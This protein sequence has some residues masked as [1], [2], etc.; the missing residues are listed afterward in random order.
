MNSRLSVYCLTWDAT[1]E[2][3]EVSEARLKVFA[4]TKKIKI[5]K[6]LRR[7]T[8]SIPCGLHRS[9]TIR[10][11]MNYKCSSYTKS[12]DYIRAGLSCCHDQQPCW[13]HWGLTA[14]ATNEITEFWLL[15]NESKKCLDIKYPDEKV[16]RQTPLDQISLQ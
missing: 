11:K 15:S 10:M 5:K 1:W 13:P 12:K 16:P 7:I 4:A 3:Q 14:A 6:L 2:Q 9:S 8:G